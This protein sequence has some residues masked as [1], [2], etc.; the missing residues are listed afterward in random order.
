[1]A[2]NLASIIADYEGK[3]KPDHWTANAT[4][5]IMTVL[6]HLKYAHYTDPENYPTPPTLYSVA[7]FLKSSIVIEQDK[8]GMY[9]QS[10]KGFVEA[11]KT[12]VMY[13]HVPPEGIDIVEWNTKTCSYETRHFTQEDLRA[14]Y[15]N[16]TS[17]NSMP[18]THPIIYQAFV[19]ITSKPDNEL[20]SIVSTANTALKEYLD[21]LLASNTSVSDFCIDDL[22]NYKKPVSLYL[23]TPPSD[24]LRLAPIFRLF[25]EMMVRQHART[26]ATYV[27]GQAKSNY[28]HKCLF[29]MDEFSSL[30]NLQS[31]AATLSYIAGYG[32][33]VFLINQGL[34]QINGIYGK[35]N[36]ILMNCH[37]KIFYAPND[38][39]T[40]QY[41]ETELGKTTIETKSKS[42]NGGRLIGYTN[43]S[44]S[45]MAR[46]LMTGDEL[47]RMEDQEVIIASGSPPVL[48]DKIKY[49]ENNYYL[50]KLIN[51]PIVSDVIRTDPVRNANAKREELLGKQTT[52]TSSTTFI[53][54][55][56]LKK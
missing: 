3:G 18:G 26:I 55:N 16:S 20:G 23:V 53:Y 56:N 21:P 54:D 28:K 6:L 35:D 46:S 38:N 44:T 48:T 52:Q 17:L 42:R 43:T 40:A 24:L 34:P 15:P 2:Q 25:F 5:V 51:A 39:D 12:L 7:A 33:K 13:E 14:I 27:N 47:K 31:F 36:Q 41:A 19:E 50:E 22:M 45:Q 32:M 30:G 49:Y 29:L 9:K 4:N 1:M 37:L 11:A 10:A 8:D